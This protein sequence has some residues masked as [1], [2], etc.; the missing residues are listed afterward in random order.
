M[1]EVPRVTPWSKTSV[2]DP[3]A[4]RGPALNRNPAAR[5]VAFSIT[6]EDDTFGAGGS[7]RNGKHRHPPRVEHL[8]FSALTPLPSDVA[9][10]KATVNK[11]ANEIAHSL[12][13]RLTADTRDLIANCCSE[14]VQLLSSEANEICEKDNKKT[15][16]PDHILRALETLGLQSYLPEVKSEYERVRNEEKG[17][18]GGKAKRDKKKK[19]DDVEELMRQQELLFAMARGDPLA[20]MAGSAPTT[21]AAKGENAMP[22]AAGDGAPAAAA[23]MEEDVADAKPPQ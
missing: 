17:R 11:F 20:A 3:A 1:W 2:I 7:E 6:M 18:A 22:E 4:Y 14:F 16:S 5:L 15:I 9:L 13:V 23:K 10:P 8:R 19:P 21:P 12:G